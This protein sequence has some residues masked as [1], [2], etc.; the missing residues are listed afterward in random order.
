[1]ELRPQSG[2]HHF[3]ASTAGIGLAFHQSECRQR[4]T[5]ASVMKA[6]YQVG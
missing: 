1:M 2:E 3:M 6:G 4:G 5:K